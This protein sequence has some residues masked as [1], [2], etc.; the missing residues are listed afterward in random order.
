MPSKTDVIAEVAEATAYIQRTRQEQNTYFERIKQEVA[1]YYIPSR[2]T[3]GIN[4]IMSDYG[5]HQQRLNAEII[6]RVEHLNNAR[7]KYGTGAQEA[8]QDLEVYESIVDCQL[9]LMTLAEESTSYIKKILE[10][11]DKGNTAATN[12]V[13]NRKIDLVNS[14]KE[15]LDR[16]QEKFP[17]MPEDAGNHAKMGALVH[18]LSADVDSYSQT[19]KTSDL[20]DDVAIASYAAFKESID[21]HLNQDKNLRDLKKQD[22]IFYP[23]HYALVALIRAFFHVFDVIISYAMQAEHTM[24]NTPNRR[25]FFKLPEKSL[26]KDIAELSMKFNAA[27]VALDKL[28]ETE[29]GPSI[30]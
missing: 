8:E 5:T 19:L 13:K 9:N 12:T 17:V 23:V 29:P 18:R 4:I 21:L 22:S 26:S 28:S 30:N 10:Q 14:L 20:F 2:E 7:K 11:E 27:I 24:E 16:L 1:D 25:P 3:R 6:T 15:A